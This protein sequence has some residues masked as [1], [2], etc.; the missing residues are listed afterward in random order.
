MDAVESVSGN[1]F[2]RRL[3][4]LLMILNIIAALL[5]IP[6]GNVL[7]GR[8]AIE[9]YELIYIIPF[10]IVLTLFIYT[11]VIS[12][13][14][15]LSGRYGYD[16]PVFKSF[17]YKRK[18]PE[19][20][21]QD[22]SY[23]LLAGIAVGICLMVLSYI[24]TLISPLHTAKHVNIPGPL[25]GFLVSVSAGISEETV[26]RFCLLQ[27]FIW[28]GGYL[29]KDE[30]VK[31]AGLLFWTANFLSGIAF[32]MA[33]IPNLAATGTEMNFSTISMTVSLNLIAGMSYGYLFFKYGLLSAMIAHF[34]TDIVL[35]VLGPVFM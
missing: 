5:S 9:P 19:N 20:V 11:F 4:S 32:G 18:Y 3:F 23:S 17:L 2:D 27:V 13:G 25:Y 21:K 7:S 24:W 30:Y 15:N 1:N 28:L 26:F 12:I 6:F 34:S 16:E 31:S 35:H 8:P 14:I 22:L 33:H 10:Q 29:I